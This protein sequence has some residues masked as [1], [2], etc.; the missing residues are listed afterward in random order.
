MSIRIPNTGELNWDTVIDAYL[1]REHNADGTHILPGFQTVDINKNFSVFP[2]STTDS[3]PGINAAI[4]A[5]TPGPGVAAFSVPGFYTCASTINIGNGSTSA[6]SSQNG[7]YVSVSPSAPLSGITGESDLAVGSVVE[8]RTAAGFPSGNAL[9]QVNGPIFGWG[10]SGIRLRCSPVGAVSFGLHLSAARSGV[11]DDLQI[12][13]F[14]VAGHYTTSLQNLT[15]S[16]SANTMKNRYRGMYIRVPLNAFAKGILWNG[17]G[18]DANTNTW[19]EI[20]DH[21]LIEFPQNNTTVT[22]YGVYLSDCDSQLLRHTRFQYAGNS[23][24]G[25]SGS[26]S[27]MPVVFDFTGT[28]LQTRPTDVVFDMVDFGNTSSSVVYSGSPL[29]GVQNAI[30]NL[31]LGN[32]QPANPAL[33][34]LLWQAPLAGSAN[35]HTVTAGS[36]TSV[37]TNTSFDGGSGSSAYTIGD[38]VAALK[39]Y[40]VLKV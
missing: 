3:A 24:N 10:L 17:N 19:G 5:I 38:I 8:L 29:S 12:L 25:S 4:A 15:L 9:V 35:A 36:T 39:T 18:V 37:F 27:N 16:M 28:G 30:A 33:S 26:G 14:A 13:D 6:V 34:R 32:T 31:N 21:L 23:T 40:G 20:Y 7:I 11:S 22:V 2:N 1:R